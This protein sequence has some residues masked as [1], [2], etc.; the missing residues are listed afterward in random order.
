MKKPSSRLVGGAEMGSQSGE[1]SG[2]D[3]GLWTGRSHIRVQ[4][5]QEEQLGSKT[6]QATQGSGVGK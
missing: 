2:Q 3:G 4:K 5:N 1:D 6:D